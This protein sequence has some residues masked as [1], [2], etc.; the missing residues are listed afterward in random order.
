MSS[1]SP[2]LIILANGFIRKFDGI[3]RSPSISYHNFVNSDVSFRN[4]NA[5]ANFPDM[6]SK[7][8]KFFNKKFVLMI[9]CRNP[10]VIFRFRF[11]VD[12]RDSSEVLELSINE[13]GKTVN[14]F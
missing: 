3:C 11:F 1:E 14:I 10:I 4:I 7:R 2:H 8:L 6:N 12:R 13:I 5:F 9:C